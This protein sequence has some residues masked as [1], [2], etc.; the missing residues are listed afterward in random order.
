MGDQHDGVFFIYDLSKQNFVY[1]NAAF[2]E[3]WKRTTEELLANPALL[4]ETIHPEDR[5]YVEDNYQQFLKYPEKTS[6]NFRIE[7]PYTTDRWLRLTAFPI[8]QADKVVWVSGLVEDA[9]ARKKNIFLMQKINARKDSMM[10]ILSH[11]LRG[12]IGVVQN[13]VNLI[14]KKLPQH[15]NSKVHD[16]LKLIQTICR[17][18]VDLIWDLVHQ[19]FLESAVEK[20]SKERL[21]LVWEIKEVIEQYRNAQ[22]N[23]SKVFELTYSQERIFV[24]VDSMKFMQ[25]INNLISNAIKFT[26]D[27]G[28]I[29]IHVEKKEETILLTLSDNGIGIPEA[30]QPVLFDKFTRARR[31]GL[32]GEETVGLGMSIVKTIVEMHNGKISF[33]SKENK[34]TTFFIEIAADE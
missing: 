24:Q 6:L 15:D 11:D 5:D 26:P 22:E 20:I 16:W 30:M 13:L 29:K 19:E 25:V 4:L 7:W 9:S 27:G 1:I 21:D 17:R 23:I 32:K 28:I 12:P 3:L 8:R 14:E 33:K 34:G 18:N 2:E 10:E 31:P